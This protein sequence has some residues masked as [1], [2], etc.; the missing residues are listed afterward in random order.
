MFL[1]EQGVA[2]SREQKDVLYKQLEALW[3]GYDV[4]R[5]YDQKNERHGYWNWNERDGCRPQRYKEERG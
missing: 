4:R 2:I 3:E 5:P 1:R